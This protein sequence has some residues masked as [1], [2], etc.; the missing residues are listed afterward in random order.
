MSCWP[1]NLPWGSLI[2][3]KSALS[4]P[5]RHSIFPVSRLIFIACEGA[6]RETMTPLSSV[7]SK[8]LACPRSQSLPPECLMTMYGVSQKALGMW[9]PTTGNDAGNPKGAHLGFP[10][11]LHGDVKRRPVVRAVCFSNRA[12]QCLR[13]PV[14]FKL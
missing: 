7:S 2:I 13:S 5:R 4:P 1:M 6:R 14:Q 8:E 12:A 10:F 11:S 3:L 9:H